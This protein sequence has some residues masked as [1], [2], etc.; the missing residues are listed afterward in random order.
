MDR[1]GVYGRSQSGIL[2]ML[3]KAAGIAGR[4]IAVAIPLL[5]IL[6]IGSEAAGVRYM[7]VLSSSMEP[8]LPVGSLIAIVPAKPENVV[9]GENLTYFIGGNYVTHKVIRNDR[10]N[11]VLITKGIAGKIEDAPVPYSAVK[12]VQ[13]LCV[14]GLGTLAEKLRT[15]SGKIILLSAAAAVFFAVIIADIIMSRRRAAAANQY[16]LTAFAAENNF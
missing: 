6:I 3:I 14:P 12:G 9:P 1:C 16:D 13:K 8:E 5:L 2:R 7:C 11:G 15:V 4:I 10:E